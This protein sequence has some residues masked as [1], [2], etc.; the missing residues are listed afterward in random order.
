[1]GPTGPTGA[2][3]ADSTVTGPTGS[4]GPTG[5][6]GAKGDQGTGVT[7]L[8]SL[9]NP[10]DLPLEG[11]SGDGY[12]IGG[13]LYVWDEVNSQ[14]DNVG[15][16]QGPTGPTG[17]TGADSN[18]TG[19]TGPLGKFT[20]SSGAPPENPQNGDAWFNSNTGK[21]FVYYDNFWVETGAAPIGP[22]GP[23]GPT[24]PTGAASEVPGPTGPT[25]FRGPTGPTGSTGPTGPTGPIST[26]PSTVP[27]PTGPTGSTGP[28][29]TFTLASTNPPNDPDIGEAW[30]N[31]ANGKTYIYY[32]NFWVEAS[33]A[34]IGPTG[35]TGPTGPVST[36]PSTVPGPTGPT[37]PTGPEGE[38][39][40][41]TGPTGP[42]GSTGPQGDSITGPTG[43]TGPTGP[44]GSVQADALIYSPAFTDAGS[45]LEFTGTPAAGTY[46]VVGDVVSFSIEVDFTNVTNF[47]SGQY[48]LTLPF[49]P[50]DKT[51][52]FTGYLEESGS[53]SDYVIYGIIKKGSATPKI[54][55]FVPKSDFSSQTSL[56]N[57][58]VTGSNPVPIDSSDKIFISGTYIAAP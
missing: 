58:S 26:E 57:N 50:I 25:G 44:S 32:D 30:F 37:G 7:I 40:N 18:I 6:T 4:T 14:W 31:T 55:L 1:L 12:L 52:V 8:G 20:I 47:G 41:V 34:D 10:E 23:L 51:F 17:P 16:I 33:S 46:V 49:Q 11:N 36:Q 2:T 43:A 39:S 28:I 5:P 22:T 35:P 9:N 45:V 54:N 15:N 38:A 56:T 48:S 21:I 29:G 19:P 42:T 3:G 53:D 24:G 27:G 13:D